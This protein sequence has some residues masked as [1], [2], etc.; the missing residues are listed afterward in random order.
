MSKRTYSVY[1]EGSLLERAETE[2]HLGA[3]VDQMKSHMKSESQWI[4]DN[5]VRRS[6]VEALDRELAN[7]VTVDGL[8]LALKNLKAWTEK[9]GKVSLEGLREVRR[10]M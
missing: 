5:F 7:V 3:V 8:N 10:L 1:L 9:N 2:P 4:V 6:F